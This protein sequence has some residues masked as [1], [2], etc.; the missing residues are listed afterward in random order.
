MN[1]F[2]LDIQNLEFSYHKNKIIL[3]IKTFQLKKAEKVFLYGPSGCGKSTFL[4]IIAGVLSAQKGLVNV[5]EHDFS[6]LSAT[7]RDKI[8]GEKIGYIF[9][10]FNLI[11]YLSVMENI[12]LP[13]TLNADRRKKFKSE[14]EL[15]EK[16]YELCQKF[17]I[18]SL[19]KNKVTEIS[20][21]QQQRVAAA[22]ALLGNPELIIADE[23]TSALDADLQEIFLENLLSQCESQQAALLFVSHDKRF[24][25]AF[26]RE[27]SLPNMNMQNVTAIQQ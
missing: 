15:T 16:A 26:H 10:M 19:L 6:Q 20:I 17:K 27:V 11:P 3:D 9:Q 12:L 4:G 5:F 8:R 22:R 18:E 21:G 23:P 14:E 25:S 2:I 1:P 7:K 13:C 24:A